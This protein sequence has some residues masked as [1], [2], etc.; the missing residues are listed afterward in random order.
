[1]SNPRLFALLT[2][3]LAVRGDGG[4]SG[5]RLRMI[6]SGMPWE[7]L[8]RLADDHGVLS[9]L[10]WAL[11]RRSLLLPVP[12]GT[13]PD[14]ASQHP[15]VQLAAIYRQHLARRQRQR[16][17]LA[18]ILREFNRASIEPLLLKGARYLIAP[19]GPWAEARDMRDIDLLVRPD[20]AGRALA[21]L[22]ALGYA[23][24]PRP[25][26]MDQ[27]L[28]EMW[29]DGQPSAVE[30]HIESLSFSA[31]K[32]LT[33]EEVW[34]RGT[35]SSSEQ[36]AFFILPAE[37]QLLHGLLHHQVSDRC[38]AQ[39]VLALKALWEFAMLAEGMSPDGLRSI[40]DQMTAKRQADVLGSC[41]VQGNRI[42]GLACPQGI[43]ITPAARAHAE[44]TLRNAAAPDWVRHGRHLA[45][46]VRFAFARE[47]L[48][49]R[50]GLDEQDVSIRT[51][52][53][54]L[55]FLTRHYRGRMLDR[56]FGEHGKPS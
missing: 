4:N 47:T 10:I 6:E 39:R 16:D 26:P 44:T 37:W 40:A 56:L 1:M 27:H 25:I 31:R 53:R 11:T 45:D 3:I 12:V 46:Q 8:A 14:G 24:D 22:A 23:R 20:D 33:T 2:D 28:P 7:A 35:H 32:I 13:A 17:Q 52:G 50:Y 48:A 43:S 41:L 54:H 36:G 55:R 15:S 42:F 9:P 21:A 18:G 38:Y 30:I 5:L 19:P 49:V 29:H 51:V 34:E